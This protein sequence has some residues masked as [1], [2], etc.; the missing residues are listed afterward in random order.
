MSFSGD[1]VVNPLV[2]EGL[3]D[4]LKGD[5]AGSF[6]KGFI[7]I[8]EEFGFFD[9][10]HEP[11]V[12]FLFDQK[13]E[14]QIN[15]QP[16]TLEDANVVAAL[17]PGYDSNSWRPKNVRKQKLQVESSNL[18]RRIKTF[19]RNLNLNERIDVYPFD[20]PMV[21]FFP[22]SQKSLSCDDIRIK[23]K[24]MD[25]YDELRECRREIWFQDFIQSHYARDL[26]LYENTTRK[27][28]RLE[29]LRLLSQ[30]I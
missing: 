22:A 13:G 19:R 26:W 2:Y 1:V 18:F 27:P 8:V 16:F 3:R 20:H 29:D 23:R 17:L 11:I 5:D 10:H 25:L 7:G 4:L 24:L 28:E 14:A 6:L 15:P 21:E 30:L 12:N 9:A